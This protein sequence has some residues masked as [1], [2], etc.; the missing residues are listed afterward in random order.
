M[1][2][3]S[4]EVL[5]QVAGLSRRFGSVVAVDD[6]SFEVR[7]G[8]CLGLLGPNGAGKSTTLAMLVGQLAPDRGT[9]TVLGLDCTTQR[10]DVMR[11][12][13]YVPDSPQ[14]QDGLTA[15]QL[16]RFVGW[17]HGSRGTALREMVEVALAEQGLAGVGDRSASAFSLG[18][19]KRLALAAASLHAPRVLVLD[20]PGSALDPPGQ[21]DLDERIRGWVRGG[22]GV[23]LC[24]HQVEQAERVCDRILLL[25]RGR[26]V[27]DGT[28]SELCARAGTRT[29][30]E[31]FHALNPTP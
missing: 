25:A 3:P 11:F 10:A 16:L 17:S 28:A 19:A 21:A 31:A 7:G 22:A 23:L 15:R 5:V 26:L 8:E 13:G 18:M 9:V 6:L 1:N 29:L 27:A 12:L 24:T 14:W 20:E 30:R 4:S 2:A